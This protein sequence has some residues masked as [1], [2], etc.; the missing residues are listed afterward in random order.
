M[1][2]SIKVTERRS[3]RARPLVRGEFRGEVA[4]EYD[5]PLFLRDLSNPEAL[6][7]RPDVAILNEKRNRV[8]VVRLALSSG[9]EIDVVV[10][11]FFSPGLPRLKTLFLP[12][13]AAK[14]WRG[15]LALK[16]RGLETAR[17]LAFLEKRR[18]GFVERSFYLASKIDG[19]EEI[20]SL[21]RR[22]SPSELETL[23]ADLA[24]FLS[25]VH[26]RGIIHRDLSDGNILV[27][28]DDGGR[29]VFYLL[30]TNRVRVRKTIGPAGRVKNLIR[31]GV[32]GRFQR[33]FLEKYLGEKKD[34]RPV[35]WTWYRMNKAVFT[36]Y[37]GLKKK[38]RL[39]ELARKLR[40]Q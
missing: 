16:E 8:G 3:P 6:W 12:S 11:E 10:K 24:G 15:A 21:F 39:R 35:L 5:D 19:T 1:S 33:F 2:E 20:R 32:P 18:K 23:L 4:A 22:L 7:T 26:E 36:G 17:P 13:K 25:S 30:D 9:R 14:A 37:V 38:L 40:I 34:L 29:L 28:R 31:L 27:R